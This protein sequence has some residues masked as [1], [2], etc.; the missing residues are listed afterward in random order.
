MDAR[1]VVTWTSGTQ[2]DFYDQ[3]AQV[4]GAADSVAAHFSRYI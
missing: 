1:A 4:G 3:P 2:F